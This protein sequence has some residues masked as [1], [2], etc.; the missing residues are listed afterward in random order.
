M[1]ADLIL[2]NDGIQFAS[3]AIVDI[4]A[5]MPSSGTYTAGSIVLELATTARI[6]GW[7][8]LTTGS[9][10]VLNTDWVYFTNLGIVNGTAVATT[11]GTA[12]DFTGIPSGVKRVTVMLSD[13]STNGISPFMLQIGDSG[14]LET[15]G[16][17]G[18]VGNTGGGTALN[19]TFYQLSTAPTSAS[20]F[21][22]AFTLT[23]LDAATNL[24]TIQGSGYLTGV[25][26]CIVGGSKP[27]S[28]TLDRLR[29]S[30]AG[31]ADTFDRG[32]I[33]ILW[34]F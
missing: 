17:L 14:G 1:P 18:G 31:G 32:S 19:S 4:K 15:S 20:T 30:T 12:V 16:Y 23:L 9:G 33:N 2:S 27:L 25:T 29:L 6:S 21:D 28:A 22:G 8:R 10:H 24:W 11:S 26:M 5:A 3:G 7:K 34:E 13:V